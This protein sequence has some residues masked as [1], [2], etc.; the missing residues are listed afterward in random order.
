MPNCR[1]QFGP[2][3][4]SSICNAQFSMILAAPNG[5]CMFNSGTQQGRSDSEQLQAATT[6]ELMG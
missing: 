4:R 3:V 6:M 1:E 2:I 5:C